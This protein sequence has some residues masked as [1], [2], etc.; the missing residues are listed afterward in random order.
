MRRKVF[1]SLISMLACTCIKAQDIRMQTL[2]SVELEV[3]YQLDQLHDYPNEYRDEEWRGTYTLL[4]DIGKNRSH[5]YVV[6]EHNS[7]MTAIQTFAEKNHWRIDIN[8][9]AQ[10]GETCCNYPGQ[11]QVTQI[12]NLDAA[13]VFQYTEE[14]PKLGWTLKEE[15]KEVLGYDCQRATCSFRGRDWEAW[16]TGE[17][18]LPYGPWKLQGLPGLILEAA[19]TKKEYRFTA[20]GMERPKDSRKMQIPAEHV[21][22]TK[23]EKAR[24]ME[25]ALHKDH[26]TFASDYGI[27]FRLEGSEHLPMPYYPAEWE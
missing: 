20:T 15:H 26:G 17:I 12:V 25:A 3:S 2:D 1:I 19:D 27:T 11:G 18:P 13:G 23:R 16:F 5:S 10:L 8:V 22:Q 7:M 14:L 6:E 9:H 21:T 24:K 4:L